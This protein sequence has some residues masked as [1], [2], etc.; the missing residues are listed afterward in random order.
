MEW[1]TF[2]GISW[3]GVLV[4][5]L[6]SF[7]FGWVWY[8]PFAFF[9]VWSRLGKL[10][11]EKLQ[12]ANMAPVFGQMM[13]GNLLGIV[14]LAML[15]AGLGASGVVAGMTLG[16]VVGVAFRT[17]AHLVHN[18]FAQRPGGLTLIDSAHDTLALVIAG[19]ALGLFM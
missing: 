17:G 8:S 4:A 11:E 10:D 9:P 1:L 15:M 18:G 13:V 3:W 19:A 6:A 7:V 2:S 16:L 5:F 12:N 14:A